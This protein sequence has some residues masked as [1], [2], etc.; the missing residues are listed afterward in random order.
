MRALLVIAALAALG[1][2]GCSG[3]WAHVRADNAK[4][5]IS[6]SDGIRGPDGKILPE[7]Q[8]QSIG[9]FEASTKKWTMLWRIIP[10]GTRT[11]D[12]SDDVNEQV[13]KAGGNAITNLEVKATH[14]VWNAFTLIGILP[15][16]GNVSVTGTVVR[17]LDRP[18]EAG[19]PVK[20]TLN[21]N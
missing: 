14:C 16:C 7:N 18:G 6:M 17:V 3:A 10:L 15:D 4:Y 9:E 21:T 12:I 20:Q 1:T 5:V 19:A 2:T 11:F 8:V 13:A